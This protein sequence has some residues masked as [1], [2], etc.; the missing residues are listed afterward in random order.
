MPI[1]VD[2]SLR[3]GSKSEPKSCLRSGRDQC[4][5]VA[6]GRSGEMDEGAARVTTSEDDWRDTVQLLARQATFVAMVPLSRPGT[7]WEL[8]WLAEQD[9]LAISGILKDVSVT[10]LS[11]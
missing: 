8:Q 10:T 11:V 1:D 4:S 9:L 5:F 3:L 7:M 2:Q 6:L